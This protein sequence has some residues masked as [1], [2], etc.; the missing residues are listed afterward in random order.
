MSQ[1]NALTCDLLVLGSGIAG[2]RGAI[3]AASSGWKVIIATKDKPRESNTEYAQGGIAAA[4][5]EGDSPSQHFEDT[6]EAGD[7]LCNAEAVKVL[8]E[9]G[10]REVLQLIEWGAAFDRE[11]GELHFTREAAHSQYRILHAKGDATGRELER[12]I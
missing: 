7:G 9:E 2:L 6:L 8:V 5:G 1:R 10:P 3:E 4:L 12:A 11:D